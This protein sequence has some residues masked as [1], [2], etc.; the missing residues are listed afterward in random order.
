MTNAKAMLLCA[1]VFEDLFL[2]KIAFLGCLLFVHFQSV[3][4]FSSDSPMK[5]CQSFFYVGSIIDDFLPQCLSA[6]L[7]HYHQ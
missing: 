4:T 2:K 7:L 3:R 1:S 6:V 5:P